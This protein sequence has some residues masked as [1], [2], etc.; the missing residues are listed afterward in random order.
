MTYINELHWQMLTTEYA[1]YNIHHSNIKT[2]KIIR[3]QYYL[4]EI[5]AWISMFS[6][7]IC[8]SK[9]NIFWILFIMYTF[10][11]PFVTPLQGAP[12]TEFPIFHQNG[13]SKQRF[14]SNVI[15]IFWQ[16]KVRQKTKWL[17]RITKDSEHHMLHVHVDFT[18][19]G[20]K[21]CKRS[22]VHFSFM[23]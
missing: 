3:L 11:R 5:I 13:F 19:K 6:I 20:I 23:M 2:H 10:Y 15:R 12:F 18:L 1:L 16:N 21:Q 4:L 8:V 22:W 14:L 7:M 9:F 17:V